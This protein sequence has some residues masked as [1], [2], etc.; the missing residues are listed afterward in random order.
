MTHSLE[1]GGDVA[2]IGAGIIGLAVAFELSARG[3]SVRVYDTHEPARAASWAAAGMLAPRTEHL[4]D[5]A[6]RALCEDSLAQYPA[7]ADAVR[8]ASGVDPH[9]R[10]DG[11]VHTAY[12]EESLAALQSWQHDLHEEGYRADLF[13]REDVLRAEPALG[14]HIGGGLLVYG[15][16]HIDN[17]RLG[18][19][20]AA[21]CVARGVRV[22]GGMK[23]LS[24]E[25]DS[26]RVLGVRSD[27]GYVATNAVVNAAGAWAAHIDGA[28]SNCVPDVH[29]IKG[30][31]LAIEVPAGFI[32]HTTWIPHGYLVPRADGRLLVGATAKDAGFDT[33]VTAGG[34][35]ALLHSAVTAVPAL[36]EFT[37]SETWAG[38]R[39][40]TPDERPFLGATP[41]QGYFL[42]CGHYRNGILLAPATSRLLAD[43]LEG[44]SAVPDAFAVG[45]YAL[46]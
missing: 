11:I 32:R 43:A 40:A 15:E 4:S 25:C 36:R 28:P 7:F 1:A 9:L 46:R 45:R 34:I 14:K 2:V 42:A 29:P 22:H 23:A 37:V 19:A 38:L 16:G 18:R 27:L 24:L 20:L 12:S 30:E 13:S 21:A 5:A 10:L 17:R 35:E 26:R 31:M 6:L 41:L 33:R 44:V 8:E 3:A 39:P